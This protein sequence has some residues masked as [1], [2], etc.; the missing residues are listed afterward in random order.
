MKWMLIVTILFLQSCSSFENTQRTQ[1]ILYKLPEKWQADG[2]IGILVNQKSQNANFSVKFGG[3]NYRF[4]I[5]GAFGMG[6]IHLELDDYGLKVEGE[7]VNMGLKSWMNQ[8]LGWHFPVEHLRAIIFS[9]VVRHANNLWGRA[10][11][12]HKDWLIKIQSYNENGMPK[13]LR[14][15][16]KHKQ[17][18][19]KLRLKNIE[20]KGL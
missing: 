16:H 18:N 8:A 14:F 1:N 19:I 12:T 10:V 13:I 6:G 2:N 4:E 7:R 3:S 15:N 5:T 20:V 9:D 11:F 17:V